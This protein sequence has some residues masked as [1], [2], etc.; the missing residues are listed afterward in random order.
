VRQGRALLEAVRAVTDRPVVL[1]L[2]THAR[3]EF[4]FGALAFRA[5]KVPIAMQRQAAGLMRSRCE[6]C[7][8][9]LNEVLG[10]D[11]MRGSAL[12]RPDVEFDGSHDDDSSGRRLKVLHFGHSS[13]PGDVVVLDERS[14][15]LFAGGLLDR[16][17]V[18]DVQD[19]ELPGWRAA[20]KALRALPVRTV[21]PGHGP[22]GGREVIDAVEGY[23]QALD[24]RVQQL[25]QQG[26]ALSEVPDAAMLPAYAGWDQ[27]PANHRRNASVLFVRLEREQL[28]A[29][30]QETPKR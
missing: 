5:S 30:P 25:L 3:Q 1:V 6:R 24:A 29:P 26:A 7:L 23:L 2:V 9:T 11:E 28:F 27:Y 12:Y 4:L 22:V 14:G 16:D 10:E 17:R 21:V 13:G 20:L 8:K 18:P 15:V 19:A